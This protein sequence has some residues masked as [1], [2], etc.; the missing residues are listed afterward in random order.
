MKQEE[1]RTIPGFPEYEASS[2]GK[3]RNHRAAGGAARELKPSVD[4]GKFGNVTKVRVVL[5][6]GGRQTTQQ[7]ARL[8]F[9]AFVGPIQ[10]GAIVCCRN[11]DMTDTRA[12]NLFLASRN[13]RFR[14]RA[15][16]IGGSNR[17]PV[18]KIDT[19][20][21]VVDAYRSASEAARKNGLTKPTVIDHANLRTKSTVLAP[22]GYI[23]A[24]DDENWLRRT[25]ERAVPELEEK[26]FRFTPPATSEYWNDLLEDPEPQ[27]DA[28]T[29]EVALPLAG[30]LSFRKTTEHRSVRA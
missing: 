24:W 30:G 11:G 22:D 25:L 21:E 27:L 26:G 19:A 16:E 18:V 2:D 4:R 8:V 5:H 6:I 10:G 17:R 28:A 23:Y 1:W 20:L 12:Q 7:V 3:I 29:W 15:K 14:K 9:S 13:D